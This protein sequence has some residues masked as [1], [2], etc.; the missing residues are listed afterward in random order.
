MTFL[1][2][3][4]RKPLT[5]IARHSLK[6]PIGISKVD[7]TK[8]PKLDRVIKGSMSK[9]TK[10]ADGTLAKLQTLLLDTVAPLVHILKTAHSGNLIVDTSVK[11]AKLAL[12]LLANAS[13]HISKERR[14]TSLKDLNRDLLTLV[15]DDEMYADVAPMFFGD[16]FEKMMKDHVEAMRC[17]RKTSSKTSNESFFQKGRPRA[18]ITTTVGV[19]TTREEEVG[20]TRTEATA[21]TIR[22]PEKRTSGKRTSPFNEVPKNSQSRDRPSSS[23]R[24]SVCIYKPTS[25][26]TLL[27]INNSDTVA[28]KG[29]S[30]NSSSAS[31][32][33]SFVSSQTFV[34]PGQLVANHA[35]SVGPGSNS[36]VQ[37]TVH[38][39][40]LPNPTSAP[41]SSIPQRGQPNVG[42]NLRNDGKRCRSGGLLQSE[43]LCVKRIS[44]SQN[45]WG[46]EACHQSKETQQVCAYGAL[47]DGGNS[48]PERSPKERRLDG[49]SRPKGCILHDSNPRTG[50]GLPEVHVQGQVLQVQFPALRPSMCALGVHQGSEAISSSAQRAGSEADRLH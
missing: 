31:K 33:D 37:S 12:R 21:T 6:K 26:A 13:A 42:G 9:D 18:N 14:K 7:A 23:T 22:V 3:C 1:R 50:Q 15:E 5:N 34:L 8:C 44:S 43:G 40:P 41:S 30:P 17:I 45:R 28:S 48:P 32:V 4:F 49:K 36:R 46:P 24:D 27:P 35:R 19:A 16:G 29:H 47:Q 25:I 38:I 11:A 2:S 10:E 20:T 39:D